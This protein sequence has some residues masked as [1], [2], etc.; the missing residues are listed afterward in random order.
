M[1]DALAAAK[2]GPPSVTK[3]VPKI[4]FTSD[5]RR[6][7]WKGFDHRFRDNFFVIV[8][9]FLQLPKTSRYTF[10]VTCDDGCQLFIDGVM[11]VDNKG[12]GR[13]KGSKKKGKKKG[14]RIKP[15]SK[16]MECNAS[17]Y[18]KHGIRKVMARFTR[19]PGARCSRCSGPALA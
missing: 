15:T 5:N 14:C 7:I 3:E 6:G 13:T 10:W 1:E 4:D 16:L 18:L 12:A 17:P 8:T 9:G 2:H 11:I 19:T